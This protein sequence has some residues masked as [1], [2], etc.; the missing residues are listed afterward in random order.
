MNIL[1][2][3]LWLPSETN[4]NVLSVNAR[5]PM[6]INFFPFTNRK[7]KEKEKKK[8]PNEVFP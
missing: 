7:K 4:K 8:I 3:R 2:H 1:Q 5:E 6:T